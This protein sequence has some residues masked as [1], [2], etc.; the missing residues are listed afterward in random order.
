[1]IIYMTAM[2]IASSDESDTGVDEGE[3][4]RSTT[5]WED[6]SKLD[7]NMLLFKAAQA[8]N[9]T[10]MLEALANGADPNWVNEEEEGRTPLMKAVETVC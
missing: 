10:V 9:L 8:R 5:S 2:D 7:P 4:S 6:M 3:D 1:M